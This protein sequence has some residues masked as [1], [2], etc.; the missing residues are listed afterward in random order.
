M[1]LA[2]LSEGVSALISGDPLRAVQALSRALEEQ[3]FHPIVHFDLAV[4]YRLRGELSLALGHARLAAELGGSAQAHALHGLHLQLA[5]HPEQAR[6]QLARAVEL[7]PD[8]RL[9][10]LRACLDI[11]ETDQRRLLLRY[12]QDDQRIRS[13]KDMCDELGIPMN[14]LRIRVHRLRRKV[15]ACVQEKLRN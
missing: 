6:L 13:R 2:P 5:H 1:A 9:G 11:L 10:P 15:E 7:E 3:P 14:A 12:H 8:Y 4:A